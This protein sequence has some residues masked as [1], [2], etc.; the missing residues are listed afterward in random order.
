MDKAILIKN[1]CELLLDNRRSDGI[2]FA[3]MNYPFEYNATSK[4][5]YSK[6]QMCKIFLRDGFIDRYSGTKLLFPGLL[7]LLTI[8]FPEVFR[9]HKNWKMSETH[10]VYW[11]LCPTIDHLIPVAKGGPDNESN[12]ITTSMIRNSAKLNWTI[13]ELGWTLHEKGE[14]SAWDGLV[15]YFIEL[16]NKNSDYEK[17]DYVKK[18]KAALLRAQAEISL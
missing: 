17:D 13:E 14:L 10:F 7:K 4:R 15:T 16:C 8:E 5:Q 2:E 11:E 3:T 18:W 9:Y 1:L 6:Y 12:W